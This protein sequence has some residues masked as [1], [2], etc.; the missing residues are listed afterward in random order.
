MK[1]TKTLVT[2]LDVQIPEFLLGLVAAHEAYADASFDEH[3]VDKR[4]HGRVPKKEK[5]A[6]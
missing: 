2:R 4:H 3:P 1:G 5:R 6:T